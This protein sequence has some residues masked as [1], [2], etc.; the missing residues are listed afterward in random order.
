ML[1]TLDNGDAAKV[2]FEKP[3][4]EEQNNTSQFPGLIRK[5][6]LNS[7][8]KLTGSSSGSSTRKGGFIASGAI[9]TVERGSVT[10]LSAAHNLMVWG[11]VS[12]PPTNWKTLEDG[13]MNEVNIRFGSG[14]SQDKD[15][16]FDTDPTG[17]APIHSVTVCKIGPPLEAPCGSRAGCVYDVVVIKSRHAGLVTFAKKLVF[18]DL[19]YD[20]IA[21]KTRAEATEVITRTSVLLD[22]RQYYHIQL[23]YGAISETRYGDTTDDSGKIVKKKVGPKSCEPRKSGVPWVHKHCLH[24]RI[25][26]PSNKEVQSYFNQDSDEGEDPAYSEWPSAISLSGLCGSTTAPGDSGGPLYAVDKKMANVYLLGVTTGVDMYP[27]KKI[28]NRAFRNVLS[29]SIAPYLKT[30]YR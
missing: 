5:R 14:S 7:T 17:T 8:I 10:I 2:L 24:Y 29:T 9:F 26:R 22:L 19:D 20:D 3:A 13:F 18:N 16:T 11:G 27:T 4:E 6:I 1:L 15:M 21:K 12:K 25:A 30:V 23:G 28:S